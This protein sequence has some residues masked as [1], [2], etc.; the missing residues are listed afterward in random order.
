[1]IYCFLL[2]NQG[3][4]FCRCDTLYSCNKNL[5]NVFPNF[6]WDLKSVLEWFRNNSP[7]TNPETSNL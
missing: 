6:K 3:F 1:M 5:E 2:V 7:N 4:V